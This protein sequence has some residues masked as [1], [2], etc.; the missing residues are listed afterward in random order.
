MAVYTVM[1]ML[2]YFLQTLRATKKRSLQLNI[3]LREWFLVGV[4]KMNGIGL[5]MRS[6]TSH[7]YE[8][9]ELG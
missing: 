1:V 2:Q 5:R 8:V 4:V 6:Y 9:L 7:N 3:D